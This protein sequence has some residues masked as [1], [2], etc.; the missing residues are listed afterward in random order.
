MS[1]VPSWRSGT[2][3]LM[4]AFA[5]LY[6]T[7]LT[8]GYFEY[9]AGTVWQYVVYTPGKILQFAF[10]LIYMYVVL[11][12]RPQRPPRA[13]AAELAV[14]L[15]SGAA[16]AAAAWLIYADVLL[17]S[18]V[19]TGPAERIVQQIDSFGLASVGVFALTAVFYSVI[20]SGLEEYYWRWFVFGRASGLLRRPAAA[21]V[22]ASVGFAAHHVVVLGGFFGYGS[23]W[24][25]V[26]SAAIAVG[27]AFWCAMAW[28]YGRLWG[29]WL[30]HALVDAAIFTIGYDIAFRSGA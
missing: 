14:G 15:A 18:G 24:T 11:G 26:L 10:P 21:A 25:W 19:L 30:S 2:G 5:L 8:L 1:R 20:H 28:R 29:A 3:G 27:G 22:L 16:I 13:S 4:L 12:W 17:P 9:L 6:P 7:L 23:I